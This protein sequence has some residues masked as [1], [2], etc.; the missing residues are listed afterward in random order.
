MIFVHCYP[1]VTHF[2]T[3][4]RYIPAHRLRESTERMM[5]KML[6]GFAAT[7]AL[8]AAA[9]AF[10]ADLPPA[11][12]PVPY[13]KAPPVEPIATWQGFYIGLEGGGGWGHTT[14]TD[15]TGFSSG[16]YDVSGG[17]VGGTLGYN[18]QF[19]QVVFGLEGDGSWADINGSTSGGGF[20][21]G[22]GGTCTAKLDALGTV[23]GRVG[24]AFGNVLPFV[25][26]GLA[27]ADINGSEGGGLNTAVGSG[28]STVTGWT[29]GGGLEWM[30]VPHWSIKG[31]YLYTDFGHQNIFTDTF[32]GGGAASEQ[33]KFNANIFRAG[34][35][36]HF[37]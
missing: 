19:N 34:V 4:M 26:G 22:G 8:V 2:F 28:S 33:E 29:V 31:E 32:A 13:Y 10:A 6:L 15:T 7:A 25:T 9:P 14:Q 1:W 21:G 37:N 35:N 12:A 17:L 16:R 24:Y 23:R 36:Y 27:I 3:F 30:V 20:C 5:K 11:A 18:W